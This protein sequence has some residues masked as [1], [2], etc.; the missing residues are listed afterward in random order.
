MEDIEIKVIKRIQCIDLDLLCDT[1]DKLAKYNVGF[2]NRNGEF[3]FDKFKKDCIK[4]I[5]L[6]MKNDIPI[7]NPTTGIRYQLYDFMSAVQT[8]VGIR[9]IG[10]FM[11]DN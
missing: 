3:K 2:Y 11:M 4:T 6:L 7:P 8:I 9:N 1:V 10:K 5:E